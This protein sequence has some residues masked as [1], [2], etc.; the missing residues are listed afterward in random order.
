VNHAS[1]RLR[2]AVMRLL[3]REAGG[4]EA[5]SEDLAA[6]AGRLLDVLSLGLAEVIGHGGV[7][8]LLLRAVSLSKREFPFFNAL[9]FPVERGGSRG[10]PFRAC[11]QGQDLAVIRRASVTLLATVAGLL[12][13]VVGERLAWSLLREVWPETLRSGTG[14]EETEA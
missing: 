8:A 9:I 14:F 3:D 11:L 5:S 6:A 7:N 4:D 12:V 1:P 13:T 10:E 2:G